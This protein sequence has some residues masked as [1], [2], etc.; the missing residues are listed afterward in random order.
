MFIS[1]T[2]SFLSAISNLNRHVIA[3]IM[4]KNTLFMYFEQCAFVQGTT[5]KS[6]FVQC[7]TV[8]L[9]NAVHLAIVML[10]Y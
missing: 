8:Q 2:L 9:R 4:S 10:V 3:L 6:S 7:G 5:H 1:C